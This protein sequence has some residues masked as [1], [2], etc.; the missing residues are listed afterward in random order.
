VCNGDILGCSGISGSVILNPRA[1]LFEKKW[2]TVFL[3]SF[4]ITSNLYNTNVIGG[5][6]AAPN[7]LTNDVA[8][9]STL[10]FAIAGLLVG[11]GSR[12]S[13][14]LNPLICYV[15]RKEPLNKIIHKH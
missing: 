11:F 4:M 6:N 3:S 12:V 5:A 10:G 8:Y 1:A 2:E 15:M 14:K 9:V 7:D 13:L